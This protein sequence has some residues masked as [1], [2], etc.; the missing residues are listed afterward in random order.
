MPVAETLGAVS[1]PLLSIVPTVVVQSKV[2]LICESR[3]KLV[4]R[5][6]RKLLRAATGKTGRC[7]TD[8]NARQ[9]LVDCHA[10]AARAELTLRVGDG[11]DE[12][13]AAGLAEREPWQVWRHWTGWRKEK[14]DRPLRPAFDDVSQRY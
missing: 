13:I 12:R 14:R 9:R 11:R 5:R 4:F 8:D 2:G 6:G 3:A 7:R 1:R 10:R